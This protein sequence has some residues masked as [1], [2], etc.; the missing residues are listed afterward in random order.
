MCNLK[1]HEWKWQSCGTVMNFTVQQTKLNLKSVKT[2]SLSSVCL[3]DVAVYWMELAVISIVT[4]IKNVENCC[5]CKTFAY[6]VYMSWMRLRNDCVISRG[7]LWSLLMKWKVGME[8]AVNVVLLDLVLESRRV[9]F[10]YF[11]IPRHIKRPN[12]DPSS[13]LRFC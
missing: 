10:E 3:C 7:W 2:V 6:F 11:E 9:S 12:D 13:Y 8:I 4:F 1:S 5:N